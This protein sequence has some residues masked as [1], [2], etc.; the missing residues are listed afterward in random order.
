MRYIV[1][2]L[3]TLFIAGCNSNKNLSQKEDKKDNVVVENEVMPEI[4]VEDE[5]FEPEPPQEISVFRAS[6][7]RINDL[8]HTKLEVKFDWEKQYLLGKATLKLKPFFYPTNVL[9]IDAKGF[10]VHKVE[11]TYGGKNKVI[12]YKYDGNQIHINL[13]K[14]YSRDENYTIFIDYI[15]KPNELEAGGS[16]A[17][18]SDKGL[19]FIN[20]SGEDKNKMPQIWTQGETEASSCWFPTIDSPNEKTTQEIY[21]TVK[22]KFKTLSNGTLISS[23]KNGDGT[24][25]DYWKQDEP[26]AP[27][28]F[29]M[30]IGE[31]VTVKDTWKR[32][33]GSEMLVDYW[34]EPEWEKYA[35]DIFGKTPKMIGYFSELLGVEYPWDKYSQIVV[36]DYVSGAMENTTAV[37]HGEFLY[38]TDRELLDAHN[39][40]II[41]HELFHHWFGDLVTC[42]S[43]SNLPM[44]ESFANYSQFLWDE[45]EHGL[46][47]ADKN[48][49]GEMEGYMLSAQRGGYHDLIWY[50]YEE[51]E[52]MF[53]GHSYNKGG[54]ILHMLRKYIGDEA[55][56]LSLKNYLDKRRF[57]TGEVHDLRL[58]FEEVTGEDLNWFFNQ[59]FFDK[60]HPDLEINQSYNKGQGKIYVTVEQKQDL[61]NFPL[62]KLPIDI[63]IYTSKG[64]KRERVWMTKAKQVFEFKSD[65]EPL[66]VNTDGDKILLCDWK[67]NKPES[68]WIYQ[69]LNGPVYLDKTE[70][71]NELKLSKNLEA[72]KAILSMLDHEFYGIKNKAMKSLYKVS[73][74]EELRPSL[75]S[76]L[77]KLTNDKDA[78]VR[79]NSLKM[80]KKYFEDDKETTVAMEKAIDD[81]SYSVMGEGLKM[82]AKKSPKKALEY[83]KGLE[84]EKNS[85]VN[86]VVADI[87][88]KEGGP[89]HHDFFINAIKSSGGIA[90]FGML[91]NYKRYM[92]NQDDKEI[93]KS[94]QVYEDIIKNGGMWWIKMQGYQALFGAEQ[95]VQNR[96][97]EVETEINN[98]ED[99]MK[100]TQL[101]KDLSVLKNSRNKIE[102]LISDCK[103]NESDEKVLEY[104]KIQ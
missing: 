75:K 54:R 91:S 55:F 16:A 90:K 11:L 62:F 63:D 21:I 45:Y 88:A 69:L 51:R 8:L 70:A 42:E 9:T 14:T 68:Q 101:Q 10:D 80:L 24:R 33:D 47:E 52:E 6:N 19:Y 50:E 41:A 56:F 18:T 31:F 15:A 99:T 82:L 85:S 97:N 46:M 2:F 53:D 27:Y 84:K 81:R 58:S 104:L 39:E 61:T 32:K 28:L 65:E 93:D 13:D 73:K 49:H 5:Y 79:K 77:L 26:H 29:M 37:I 36:R 86:N 76:K 100:Q 96:I 35:K 23:K 60:G 83:A 92:R 67:D 4:T 17:I 94:L 30:G 59:W 95:K 40:S 74:N 98:T 7:K 78:S 20:P 43:W 3:F 34:V 25:T 48:A 44:N 22:D 71:M 87:Y 102:T 72:Q 57:N 64:K 89:E 1:L 103:K 38:R 12:D 66:L